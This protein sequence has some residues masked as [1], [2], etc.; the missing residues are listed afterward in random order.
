MLGQF[1]G[2]WQYPARP[3]E[4]R[5]LTR[6]LMSFFTL[7]L[8]GCGSA[9]GTDLPPPVAEVLAELAELCTSVN[10]IPHMDNAVQRADLNGDSAYDFVLFTGAVQCEN[11]PGI[12]GDRAKGVFLFAGDGKG[13]ATRAFDGA[14]YGAT[15]EAA[16]DG[17]RLWLTT[18]G[19]DCGS[20]PAD[21]FADETF[22]ERSVI[23][24]AAAGRFEYAPLA[25]AR[26]LQ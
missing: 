15:I 26:T 17:P 18:S 10:G 23:W 1:P 14:V 24:N 16:D 19:M 11:A 25:T 20:N 22:C 3:R 13:G 21:T 7:A 8:A 5:L 4:P 2:F 9:P 12:F 6:L